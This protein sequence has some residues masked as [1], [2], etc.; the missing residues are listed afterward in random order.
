MG[1]CT[2]PRPSGTHPSG[3]SVPCRPSLVPPRADAASGPIGARFDLIS[4]KVSHFRVVSPEY[5]EKACHSPRLQNGSGKSPLQILRFP[6][7]PAFSPKEL[8]TL[9]RP[10]AD[11]I[12]KMMKCRLDVHAKGSHDT[13]TVSP[14]QAAPGDTAP[15]H[16]QRGIWLTFSSDPVTLRN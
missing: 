9:F 14:Q 16:A 5:P 11:F 2:A 7:R 6:F 10:E 15:H 8:L 12:V 13:P 1:I 3:R 4:C